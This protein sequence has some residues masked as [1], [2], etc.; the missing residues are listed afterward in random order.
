M[1]FT[2]RDIVKI[3][4][5][6]MIEQL[7]AVTIGMFDSMMVSQAGEAAIS[8]V[9]L[10]D[11]VNLLLINLF[12]ALSAGGA[13]IVS[14]YLGKKDYQKTAESAKQLVLTV[15]IISSLIAVIA[16]CIR[17]PL[18]TLIF[19]KIE[20]DV[21]ANARI[22][23]LIT[24][25]SYPFLGLYSSGAAIFRSMGNSKVSMFV[26][27][28][29]NLINVSGNAYFIFVLHIGAAGAALATLIAR[30]V[31]SIVILSLLRNKKHV[32]CIRGV[33]KTKLDWS[34]IKNICRIG[35][36]NG[37]ENSMF[38]LGKV[39]TQSLVSTFGTVSIAA[40]AVANTL[41]Q[42]QFIPSSA[43]NL[44]TPPI[45]GR[46][47]GARELGQ[48][49]S[50]SRKLLLTAYGAIITVSAVIVLLLQ[51]LLNIYDLS[52]ESMELARKLILMHSAMVCLIWPLSFT[53]PNSFR[54]AGD[55]KFTL[56]V[57]VL[58]MWI[59]RVGSSF[60]YAQYLGFGAMGV[61]LAMFT[62]WVCRSGF[63]S[64]HYFKNTWLKKFRSV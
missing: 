29:M 22:Y 13:V 56:I 64:V 3:V 45:V 63:F 38:Q 54:A 53:L 8:G 43:I 36:P 17:T 25:L 12:S 55:V 41:T 50:Y 57:A 14:Q 58:S 44:A 59:C 40:N 16:I 52:P 51:P 2:K 62:D 47:I 4:I 27:L 6:L 60:F 20:A 33:L 48:A 9:S 32:A 24:V 46:C 7:L 26:S 21:M 15:S 19:G 1:L 5:P 61:W 31:G 28:L 34:I 35:V 42:L 18:L 49:K 30:V 37:I 39:I 10:V 11:S 23:F